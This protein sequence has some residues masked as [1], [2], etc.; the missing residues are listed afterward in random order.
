LLI[1]I[2]RRWRAGDKEVV[3]VSWGGWKPPAHFLDNDSFDA[4]CDRMKK[5]ANSGVNF[6]PLE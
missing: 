1:A 4:F 3:Q 6:V 5:I 2:A